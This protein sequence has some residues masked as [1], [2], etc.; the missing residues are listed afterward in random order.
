[1]R[2]CDM[3]D[4]RSRMCFNVVHERRCGSGTL[5]VAAWCFYRVLLVMG[6]VGSGSRLMRGWRGEVDDE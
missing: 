6:S 2:S 3:R 4:A 1:M 5:M